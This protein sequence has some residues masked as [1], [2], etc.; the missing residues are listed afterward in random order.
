MRWQGDTLIDAKTGE[1]LAK[2]GGD[3]NAARIDV[4]DGHW[5]MGGRRYISKGDAMVAAERMFK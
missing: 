1:I 4:W 2:V 5:M 3:D